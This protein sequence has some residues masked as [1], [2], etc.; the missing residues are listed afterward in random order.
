[1]TAEMMKYYSTIGKLSKIV[2]S[3]DSL[4]KII[5]ESSKAILETIPA[6]YFIVWFS[7]EDCLKPFYWI[8]DR[9]FTLKSHKT[10]EGTVGKVFASQESIQIIDENGNADYASKEEIKEDFG[11]FDIGSM[12]CVPFSNKYE[13]LGCVQLVRGKSSPSF[14]KEEAE[15]IEILCLFLAMQIDENPNINNSNRFNNII[16]SARGI[17]KSFKNGDT[18]SQILKGVNIDVFEG[19]FLVV[20]GESGCGKSTFLNIIGGMETCDGGEYSFMGEKMSSLTINEL[21]EY[22]RKNIGFIFQSYNLMPNLTAIDNL[23]LIAELVDNPMDSEEALTLVGLRE[24]M[25]HYPSR[26]SGGQ[27]QRIS[28]AR[29]LVK[30][31]KLIFADEPTAALDY[32]TSIE[33][34][35]VLEK[36]VKTGTSLVMVTHNEEITRMADR[37]IR[38]RNG[39]CYEVTINKHPVHAEEL[40][41]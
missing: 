33:V 9:D 17:T 1:M 35:S 32:T 28:I 19:E 24:K 29:A 40:V 12:V 13:K 20:L 34:L 30:R 36:V 6:D 26:L 39:K 25:T 8:G 10:G 38:M 15:I 22:R 16:L 5:K 11:E 37:V 41:W 21:T 3:N 14:T 7:V 27:Q 18:V 23:N 31:P 4:D 2:S